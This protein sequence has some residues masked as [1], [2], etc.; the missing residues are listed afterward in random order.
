MFELVS[1]SKAWLFIVP[2]FR[3][4]TSNIS[5]EIESIKANPSAK[6][7]AYKIPI[8][9]NIFPKTI[10]AGIKNIICLDKDNIALFKLFPIAWKKIPDGICIPFTIH[11]KRYI[12]KAKQ[13]NFMYSSSPLPKIA[14]SLSGIS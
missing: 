14:I 9:P 5:N 13:A 8:R 4:L 3:F 11:N 10:N 2:L 6:G 12:L 7:P 1:S